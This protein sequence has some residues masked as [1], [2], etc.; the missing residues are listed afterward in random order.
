MLCTEAN[1]PREN[2][3][4]AI[5]YETLIA[6]Q[7]ETFAWYARCG[8]FLQLLTIVDIIGHD[9]LKAQHHRYVTLVVQPVIQ[10][11]YYIRTVRPCY[12]R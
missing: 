1:M 8:V 3:M 7:S 11:V 6:D 10:R 9:S 2:P 12:I 5:C 4:G